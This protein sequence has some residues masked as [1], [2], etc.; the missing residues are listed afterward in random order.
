M[1]SD[2]ATAAFVAAATDSATT[3]NA[4]ADTADAGGIETMVAHMD[5]ALMPKKRERTQ[6]W[7]VDEKRALLDLVRTSAAIV[8]NKRLDSDLTVLKN[9][10]WRHIHRQFSQQY[11]EERSCTRLKEQWRRMKANA[12]A[13]IA[14]YQQRLQ[15]CGPT[16][17]NRRRPAQLQID[18]FDFTVEAKKLCASEVGEQLDYRRMLEALPADVDSD[19]DEDYSN[20]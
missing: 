16:I 5:P 12:R 19:I 6:N 3:D 9:K 17:A 4:T 10:V 18:I 20:K 1:P 13:D 8:E 15:R 7:A 2:T 11:G 14:S